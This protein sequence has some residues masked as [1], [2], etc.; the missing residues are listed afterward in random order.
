MSSS[1]GTEVQLCWGPI[2]HP[3]ECWY[4]H[5]YPKVVIQALSFSMSEI[6]SGRL[7]VQHWHHLMHSMFKASLGYMRLTQINI[8]RKRLPCKM[9]SFC[10][11]GYIDSTF[12]PLFKVLKMRALMF[13]CFMIREWWEVRRSVYLILWEVATATFKEVCHC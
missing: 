8:D 3:Y 11:L 13:S 9:K 5:I 12:Y 6:E 4:I 1:C 10:R 2:Q 7:G